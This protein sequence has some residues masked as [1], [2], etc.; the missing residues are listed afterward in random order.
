MLAVNDGA[1]LGERACG[2]LLAAVAFDADSGA[3]TSLPDGATC[4]VGV[5]VGACRSTSGYGEWYL[6]R[7]RKDVGVRIRAGIEMWCWHQN[8][9][10]LTTV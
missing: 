4:T 1:L 9:S 2:V 7:Y 5:G 8:L 10:V 6:Q 3:S